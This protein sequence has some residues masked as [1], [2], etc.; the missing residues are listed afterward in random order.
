M[1]TQNTVCRD[2][3]EQKEPRGLIA[4]PEITSMISGNPKELIEQFRLH[5][6]V[7]VDDSSSIQDCRNTADIIAWHNDT[8]ASLS[9]LPHADAIYWRTRFLT[10]H[11]LRGKHVSVRE[12]PRLHEG[13]YHPI[14][15][16]PLYDSACKKLISVAKQQSRNE[17]LSQKDRYMTLFLSDGADTASRTYSADD[18]ARLAEK[19]L[20]T[21][22]HIISG[23]GVHDG[24]TDFSQV[25]QSMG[26]PPQWIYTIN[27]SREGFQRGS[28]VTSGSVGSASFGS[29][30]F[31]SMSQGGFTS[32]PDSSDSSVH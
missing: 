4:I 25:F 28:E 12:A 23:M 11:S 15:D 31:S 20:K 29:E 13:N 3:E 8:L 18:S 16:T 17:Y 2:N 22:K 6:T 27:R 24:S 21:E 26:I 5:V 30:S 9:A 10:A 14:H 7:V 1:S 19:M 32:A